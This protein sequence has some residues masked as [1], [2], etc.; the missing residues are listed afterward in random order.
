[1]I[2]KDPRFWKLYNES[3]EELLPSLRKIDVAELNRHY[4][5]FDELFFEGPIHPDNSEWVRYQLTF[6]VLEKLREEA[7]RPL[8]VLDYGMQTGVISLTFC[9]SGQDLYAVDEFDF[10]GPSFEPLRNELRKSITITLAEG[11]GRPTIVLNNRVR[12]DILINPPLD[13]MSSFLCVETGNKVRGT[14]SGCPPIPI[15]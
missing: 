8:R 9:R 2:K 15:P 6:Q 12:R 4:P 3:Y 5:V 13:S 10:Y 11:A 14:N 7:G 1:M